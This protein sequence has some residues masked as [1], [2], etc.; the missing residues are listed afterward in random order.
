MK[1][2]FKANDCTVAVSVLKS[3]LWDGA[4]SSEVWGVV[5]PSAPSFEKQS[6]CVRFTIDRDGDTEISIGIESRNLGGVMGAKMEKAENLAKEQIA[7]FETMKRKMQGMAGNPEPIIEAMRKGDYG[8]AGFMLIMCPD[9]ESK[10]LTAQAKLA[11]PSGSKADSVITAVVLDPSFKQALAMLSLNQNTLSDEDK[12]AYQF[13]YTA[14]NIFGKAYW[15]AIK[16]EMA[17]A[18]VEDQ[19]L[20]KIEHKMLVEYIG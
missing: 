15:E 11:L 14:R 16:E 10:S 5:S 17:A 18:P 12:A 13:A 3:R 19:V 8:N 20:A 1:A 4:V 6:H 7:Y 9:P 2:T